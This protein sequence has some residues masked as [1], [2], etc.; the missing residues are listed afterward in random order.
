MVSTDK[1]AFSKLVK[2]FRAFQWKL[3]VHSRVHN[4]PLLVPMLSQINPL[5]VF[6]SDPFEYYPPVY[7]LVLL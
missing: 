4:S 1:L 7:A 5:C 2:K 3:Q 6:L